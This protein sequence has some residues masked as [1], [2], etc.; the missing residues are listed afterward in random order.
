MTLRDSCHELITYYVLSTIVYE[1]VYFFGGVS[2]WSVSSTDTNY[3][4]VL[5]ARYI[6]EE[7]S[8]DV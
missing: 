5:D 2:I 8:V 7:M 6:T 4:M 1:W 3:N